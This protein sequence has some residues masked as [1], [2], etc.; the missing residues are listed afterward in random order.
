MAGNVANLQMVDRI[1]A[2]EE[3]PECETLDIDQPERLLLKHNPFIEDQVEMLAPDYLR[4]SPELEDVKQRVRMKFLE[5]LKG[6]KIR[7]SLAYHS[8]IKRMILNDFNDVGRSRKRKSHF[9][10]VVIDEDGEIDQDQCKA[11]LTISAGMD[12]P[13]YELERREGMIALLSIIMPFVAHLSECQR[14]AFV[15]F[16]IQTVD[17][18]YIDLLYHFFNYYHIKVIQE[19]WPTDKRERQCMKA[20]LTYAKRSIV[21]SLRPLLLNER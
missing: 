19:K 11:I 7:S 20:N 21:Q 5:A 9:V 16:L 13:A 3:L 10:A 1:I 6:Q 17:A 4:F 12:D 18:E 15:C 2:V 14:I 8:Y